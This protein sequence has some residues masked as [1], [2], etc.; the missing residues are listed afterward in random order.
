MGAPF[1]AGNRAIAQC[2]RCG[3]QFLLKKLTVQIV[4]Q[5]P[6]GLLVC[7]RCLD[8]DHPQLMLG[9][10]PVYDPQAL[11]NPRI[12]TSYTISGN[13]QEGSRIIEWGWAP[14]GM[15]TILGML[16]HLEARGEVGIVSVTT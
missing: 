14:V 4:K 16:N 3:F 6:T 7:P 11:R 13:L 5:R 1:A 12:D 2:D 15:V 8:E 10:Q 9:T